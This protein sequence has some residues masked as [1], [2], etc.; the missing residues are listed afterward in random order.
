MW[1]IGCLSYTG[2]K[3]WTHLCLLRVSVLMHGKS[4]STRS[5]SICFVEAKHIDE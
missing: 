1:N 5:P 2:Q 4:V 3:D